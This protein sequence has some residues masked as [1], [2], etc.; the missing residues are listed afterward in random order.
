MSGSRMS[1]WPENV[2]GGG[3]CAAAIGASDA[4]AR[5]ARSAAERMERGVVHRGICMEDPPAASVTEGGSPSRLGL[6]GSGRLLL[7]ID[8]AAVSRAARVGGGLDP[9]VRQQVDGV[10]LGGLPG[11]QEGMAAAFELGPGLGGE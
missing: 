1:S 2:W 3:G 5:L 10:D 9:A 6:A 8:H 4:K 11:D 7:G